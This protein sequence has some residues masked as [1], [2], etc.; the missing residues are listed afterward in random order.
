M[1][2]VYSIH[3]LTGCEEQFGIIENNDSVVCEL[4]ISVLL[5]TLDIYCVSYVRCKVKFM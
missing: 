1:D 2:L 5:S 4:C 3:D